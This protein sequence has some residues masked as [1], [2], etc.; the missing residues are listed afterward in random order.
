MIETTVNKLFLMAKRGKTKSS[1]TVLWMN[2]IDKEL[3][4]GRSICKQSISS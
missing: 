4:H 3:D 2:K 1:N